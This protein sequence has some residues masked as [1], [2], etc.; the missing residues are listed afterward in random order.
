MAVILLPLIWK[1]GA[2]IAVFVTKS[3][4]PS[5]PAPVTVRTKSKVTPGRSTAE[6]FLV[7]K[8]RSI[9]NTYVVRS[10][11]RSSRSVLL[12]KANYSRLKTGWQTIHYHERKIEHYY[13]ITGELELSLLKT[14]KA[15]LA[16][17]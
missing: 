15:L 17:N 9:P 16:K 8:P 3:V 1:S 5:V 11:F 6:K 2:E 12:R 7:D 10:Q 4:P 14:S 13:V